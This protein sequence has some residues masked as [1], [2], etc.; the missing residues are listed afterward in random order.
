VAETEPPTT[1]NF[2]TSLMIHKDTISKMLQP[3]IFGQGW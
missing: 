1:G 2:S 3:L